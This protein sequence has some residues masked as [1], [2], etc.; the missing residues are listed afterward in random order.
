[1]HRNELESASP[2][3]A[4]RSGLAAVG[5]S[6]ITAGMSASD[7]IVRAVGERARLLGDKVLAVAVADRNP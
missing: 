5:N 6:V 4:Q 1:M 2:V 3:P 7:G